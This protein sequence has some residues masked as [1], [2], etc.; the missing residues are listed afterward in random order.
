MV[1]IYIWS[2]PTSYSTSPASV[3]MASSTSTLPALLALLVSLTCFTS[4]FGCDGQP[5]D[6][7]QVASST[8]T[9]ADRIR[10]AAGRQLHQHTPSLTCFASKPY[11]LLLVGFLLVGFT[12][13]TSRDMEYANDLLHVACFSCDTELHH[14]TPRAQRSHSH[15]P[16][17]K[18][19]KKI[20][21]CSV[22]TLTCLVVNI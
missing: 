16:G 13:F 17:S 12:C 2:M 19:L 6:L 3:A 20:K 5:H 10:T 15:V 4:C 8:S 14:H 21:K 9:A 22:L 1:Y 7:L 18:Y 11:L